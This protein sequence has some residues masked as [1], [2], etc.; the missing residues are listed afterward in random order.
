MEQTLQLP[1][2]FVLRLGTILAGLLVFCA[3]AA[4]MHA[5]RVLR[6]GPS[7]A[8]LFANEY[9]L[10][11]IAIVASGVRFAL[12]AVDALRPEQPFE[13]RTT[14][15]FYLDFATDLGKLV[16][17]ATF[18]LVVM[19]YYGLPLHI[20]RDLYLT[21]QSFARRVRDMLKYHRIMASIDTRFPTVAPHELDG[22]PD[23]TCIVC[24]EDMGAGAK[25]LHCG[26]VFH[27]KC[28][29]SWLERQQVCPTCRKS[30][31]DEPPVPKPRYTGD[32]Y[33]GAYHQ[34]HLR[35]SPTG[36]HSAS[37]AS[38]ASLHGT[39][40]NSSSPPSSSPPPSSPSTTPRAASPFLL[41]TS[42][43]ASP[44]LGAANPSGF[45]T[46][47]LVLRAA[48]P[49]VIIP[50]TP[51]ANEHV[52]QSLD[53]E[54]VRAQRRSRLL[55]TDPD[56]DDADLDRLRGRSL[57][58]VSAQIE[59]VEGLMEEH[60]RILQRLRTVQ[61]F[62]SHEHVPPTSDPDEKQSQ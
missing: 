49:I 55:P 35:P 56:H 28:L 10:T 43:F 37:S 5:D 22:L 60:Q 31:M 52:Q 24:R 39:G 46:S 15:L 4:W 29:K 20:V 36:S 8:I 17:Y 30:V 38:S 13:H 21:V 34:Q 59:Y 9:A 14:L 54:L 44:S 62:M 6:L 23:R 40:T 18:F 41:A 12:N 11:G 51:A 26:H 32:Q 57:E 47:N 61:H 33:P 1:R 25:R 2:H 27:F 53:A 16:T 19:Y 45:P 50:P 48:A 3:G 58:H 42:T 7:M